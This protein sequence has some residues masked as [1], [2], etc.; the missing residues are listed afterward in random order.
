MAHGN[1]EHAAA[2]SNGYPA[3]PHSSEPTPRSFHDVCDE[4][5]HRVDAFLAEE[6]KTEVLRNVQAQ[7]R[8]S[9]GVVE[10]ALARYR[11][12]CAYVSPTFEC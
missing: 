10:E 4:L 11:C 9:M 8:V 12:V 1:G 5:R 3:K 6:Q 2:A 7:L